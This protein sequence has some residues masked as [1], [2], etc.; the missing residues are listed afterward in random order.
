MNE[1][2][3][4]WQIRDIAKLYGWNMQYHTYN[5]MRSQA[6]WPDEVLCHPIHRRVI[7]VELKSEKGNLSDAQRSWLIVLNACG[8]ETAV[9][10]PKDIPTAIR[11]LGPVQERTRWSEITQSQSV[12]SGQAH[13][14]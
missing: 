3:F 14:G 7:F 9:W 6:G 11:V 4:R 10:R 13:Q 12:S 8:L 1:E 5:S 2:Q